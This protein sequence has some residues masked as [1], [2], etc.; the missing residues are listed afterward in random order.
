MMYLNGFSVSKSI[1]LNLMVDD[2]G[3]TR[4]YLFKFSLI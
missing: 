2:A 4:K 1:M 3:S